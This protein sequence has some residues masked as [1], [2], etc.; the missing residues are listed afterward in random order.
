MILWFI[1]A[2]KKSYYHLVGTL[3]VAP[4]RSPFKPGCK[5]TSGSQ[6][7]PPNQQAGHL[8]QQLNW[9]NGFANHLLKP[10]LTRCRVFP[11]SAPLIVDVIHT[12]PGLYQI[13]SNLNKNKP[14]FMILRHCQIEVWTWRY[15]PSQRNVC[16]I[17]GNNAET[18]RSSMNLNMGLSKYVPPMLAVSLLIVVMI[19]DG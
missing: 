15:V 6:S 13:Y 1:L 16:G 9:G 8:C 4:N 12:R 10:W 3:L 7:L 19:S 14:M 5:D 11:L 17:D 2:K 18:S